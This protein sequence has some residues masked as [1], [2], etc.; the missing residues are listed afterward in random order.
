MLKKGI[1]LILVL[2]I[3]VP[4]F[5]AENTCYTGVGDGYVRGKASTWDGCHDATDGDEADH[6]GNTMTA[7][8]F[9]SSQLPAVFK[10]W[11]VFIP[12]DLTNEPKGVRVSSATISLYVTEMLLSEKNQSGLV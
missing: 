8:C 2:L 1:G 11:R 6:T 10:I 4:A 12:V 7:G 3:T 9:K 5:G